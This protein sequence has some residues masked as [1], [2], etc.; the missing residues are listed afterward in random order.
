MDVAK[1]QYEKTSWMLYDRAKCGSDEELEEDFLN[2]IPCSLREVD[3]EDYEDVIGLVSLKEET[4][5]RT[6]L[7]AQLSVGCKDEE[8][9]KKFNTP[10]ESMSAQC[11][12]DDSQ[13]VRWYPDGTITVMVDGIEHPYTAAH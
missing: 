12:D 10:M 8:L 6:R 11:Q 3:A 4:A 1:S 2:S 7:D 9:R 5:R 13:I